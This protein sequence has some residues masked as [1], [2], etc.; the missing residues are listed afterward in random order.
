M[1]KTTLLHCKNW[2]SNVAQWTQQCLTGILTNLLTVLNKS[3]CTV[4]HFP[5]RD[6]GHK[7]GVKERREAIGHRE[8]DKHTDLL[9]IEARHAQVRVCVF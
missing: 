1:S 4:V 7:P 5:G 2:R 6:K 9:H 3:N 8:N